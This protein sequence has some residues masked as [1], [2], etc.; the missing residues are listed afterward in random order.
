MVPWSYAVSK[1]H[2]VSECRGYFETIFAKA[3]KNR[4]VVLEKISSVYL[5]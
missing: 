1:D 3:N 5:L 2:V 4:L